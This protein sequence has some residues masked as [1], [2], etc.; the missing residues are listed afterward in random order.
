MNLGAALVFYALILTG[1]LL[2]VPVPTSAV[3]QRPAVVLSNESFNALRPGEATRAD[4]LLS[5]GE[6]T[7]RIDGDQFLLYE[8]AGDYGFVFIGPF[9]KDAFLTALNYLCFEF[10]EDS[11]LMRRETFT[12][13]SLVISDSA[14][15]EC[16]KQP[17]K[18]KQN[19]HRPQHDQY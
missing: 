1:C 4:V 7:S 14:I 11:V 15:I 3:H 5:L 12:G 16:T 6:P 9:G 19:W 10:R 18:Q 2:P 17:N 8:W 13:S